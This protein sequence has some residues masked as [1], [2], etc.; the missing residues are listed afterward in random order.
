MK[1]F[2]GGFD[3]FASHDP[4]FRYRD[5]DYKDR[6]RSMKKERWQRD[7]N[8]K[9]LSGHIIYVISGF[10]GL[11]LSSVK[12]A[13]A[14]NGDGG[15]AVRGCLLPGSARILRRYLAQPNGK[16]AALRSLP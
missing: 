14:L 1:V 8:R 9:H 2:R 6:P 7:K 5:S 16:T 13:V 4:L 15:P 3:G 11:M 12:F 10:Y